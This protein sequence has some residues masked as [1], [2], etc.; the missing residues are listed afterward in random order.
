M[1]SEPL[2]SDLV[3]RTLREIGK[4]GVC[5]ELNRQYRRIYDRLKAF[6]RGRNAKHDVPELLRRFL[7]HNERRYRAGSIGR[8]R[9]SHLRRAV[10]LL[11]ECLVSG[12]IEW[13]VHG[14]AAPPMPASEEFLRLHARYLDNLRTSGKSQETIESARNIIRQFLVFLDDSGS[15]TL[16]GAPRT[17]MPAFFQHLLA[18]YQPTSIRVVASHLRSFLQFAEGGERLLPLGLRAVSGANRSFRHSRIRNTQR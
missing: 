18:R 15:R 12:Q 16:G 5:P 14:H 11:Q 17:V 6:A 13:K 10:L 9:R 1:Q 3:E 4:F 2:L 8:A 7:E